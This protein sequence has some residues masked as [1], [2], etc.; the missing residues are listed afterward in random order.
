MPAAPHHGQRHHGVN[1]T[2]QALDASGCPGT[3]AY[4][5]RI[6]PMITISPTSLANG[7][8]NQAYTQTTPFVGDR[9]HRRLHLGRHRPAA[10]H[11]L[12][13]HEFQDH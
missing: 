5:F 6:C 13:Q 12:G 1:I 8:I 7:I 9:R 2:I 10:E 3:Q 4:V 11:G